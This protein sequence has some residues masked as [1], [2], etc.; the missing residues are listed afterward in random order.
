MAIRAP[1]EA[2]PAST[3]SSL[4]DATRQRLLDRLRKGEIAV[5]PNASTVQAELRLKTREVTFTQFAWPVWVDAASRRKASYGGCA[6]GL[7]LP[8]EV[9]LRE[10]EQRVRTLIAQETASN[11]VAWGLG[12]HGLGDTA[13]V[14]G[15]AT[16]RA[17]EVRTATPCAMR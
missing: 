7:A 9:R 5:G 16:N 12:R 3:V 6:A 15:G 1:R 8:G 13:T 11:L 17:W 14:I 2:L 10:G 4:Q